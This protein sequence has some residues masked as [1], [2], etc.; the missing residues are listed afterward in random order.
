MTITH[1]PY[2]QYPLQAPPLTATIVTDTTTTA[3]VPQSADEQPS[4]IVTETSTVSLGPS[5]DPAHL[6]NAPPQTIETYTPVPRG[7]VK[8]NR[9]FCKNYVHTILIYYVNWVNCGYMGEGVCVL[10]AYC[11]D[12]ELSS[13]EYSDEMR[14]TSSTRQPGC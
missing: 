10:I 14:T 2:Q 5:Q 12:S 8:K 4:L 3:T 7:T 9:R 11:A 1:S 6:L 13:F